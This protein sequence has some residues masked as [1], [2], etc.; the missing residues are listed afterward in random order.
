MSVVNITKP[1]LHQLHNF[2]NVVPFQTETSEQIDHNPLS[3][4]PFVEQC[5]MK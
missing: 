4:F 2:E 5:N 3:I 1:V